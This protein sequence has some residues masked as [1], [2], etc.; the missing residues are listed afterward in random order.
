MRFIYFLLYIFIYYA[1]KWLIDWLIYAQTFETGFIRSTLSKSRLKN[2]NNTCMHKHAYHL[3]NYFPEHHIFLLGWSLPPSGQT[4]LR[5]DSY[6]NVNADSSQW[7]CHN[8]PT[9]AKQPSAT[10][11]T[12]LRS[13]RHL[14]PCEPALHL[15]RQFPSQA[16]PGQFS[17]AT[18]QKN[19]SFNITGCT[20]T[21]PTNIDILFVSSN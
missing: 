15:H 16:V 10:E 20:N 3:N 21:K 6:S 9:Y 8:V 12:D 7:W 19:T 13:V 14:I 5:T 4:N 1:N 11:L 2:V 17:Q 18:K